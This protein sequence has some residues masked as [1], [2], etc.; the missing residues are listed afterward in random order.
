MH[1]K[2]ANL[3]HCICKINNNCCLCLDCTA[4]EDFLSKIQETVSTLQVG[5]PTGERGN[6][7]RGMG[8]THILTAT[9][10]LVIIVIDFLLGK[11]WMP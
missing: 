10:T 7:T 4:Q 2:R 3:H 6:L 1:V 11:C 5:M 9:G 8:D